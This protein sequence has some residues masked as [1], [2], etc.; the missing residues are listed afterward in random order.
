MPRRK[1]ESD[2][3]SSPMDRVGKSKRRQVWVESTKPNT[4]DDCKNLLMTRH[5]EFVERKLL[6]R[7]GRIDSASVRI[8]A[9]SA[10]RD[11]MFEKYVEILQ[12]L[13]PKKTFTYGQFL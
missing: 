6:N 8:F 9:S 5:A 2:S 3:K 11:D 7:Y 13:E 12:M 4:L 1:F 10:R